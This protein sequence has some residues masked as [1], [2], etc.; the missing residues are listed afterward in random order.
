MT[1]LN[2]P[3]VKCRR[4]EKTI[5][6]ILFIMLADI[7]FF[8]GLSSQESADRSQI[9]TSRDFDSTSA[10][11]LLIQPTGS[12]YGMV[13]N[14]PVSVANYSYS[15]FSAQ[16]VLNIVELG[17][18]TAVLTLQDGPLWSETRRW[19]VHSRNFHAFADQMV[20]TGDGRF[21]VG[22]ASAFFLD[23]AAFQNGRSF[24]TGEQL[25]EGL[26]STGFT[27]QML[28]HIFGRESPASVKDNKSAWH[29]FPSEKKYFY[30][31]PKYYS[32]PSGHIATAAM[33]FTILDANYP[34]ARAYLRPAGYVWLASLGVGLAAKK[35]HWYSDFPIGLA[36]GYGFGEI[37]TR[38]AKRPDEDTANSS[39]GITYR[40]GPTMIGRGRGIMLAMNF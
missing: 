26:L 29:L 1:V 19:Y 39:S 40:I 32:F 31:Q 38:S 8:T 13:S 3:L 34:E 17:S 22:I 23:A 24:R 9:P 28:K 25:V 5:V 2:N 35:M 14:V 20:A 27:V 12:W 10:A 16:H 21:S 18:V 4:C 7:C 11:S 33:T 37:I 30:N 6:V 36:L 15:L